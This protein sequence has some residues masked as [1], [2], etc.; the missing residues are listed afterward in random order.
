[1]LTDKFQAVAVR[2]ERWEALAGVDLPEVTSLRDRGLAVTAQMR[3]GQT[4]RFYLL[5]KLSADGLLSPR[6]RLRKAR[7]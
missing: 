3:D 6:A 4:G 7:A 1:M 2:R 5:A